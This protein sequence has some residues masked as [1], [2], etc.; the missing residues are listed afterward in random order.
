MSVARSYAQAVF[1]LICEKA[2]G[3]PDALQAEKEL[4]ALAASVSASPE[5][6]RLLSGTVIS[7]EQR[8]A[9]VAAIA[10]KMNLSP[11][12]L[13][14]AKI[15]AEKGR[16]SLFTQ[17]H[18]EYVKIRV[19]HDGGVLGELVSAEPIEPKDQ[20]ELSQ[21]FAKKL[22]KKIV[23]RTKVDP[24]LIAGLKVVVDGVTYDGS[25]KA[26]LQRAKA[27]LHSITA[28]A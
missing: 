2:P 1:E 10:Q 12:V 11:I 20:E 13:R 25:V 19:G 28:H 18:D 3:A 14:A 16:V 21:A 22:G 6:T 7:S 15:A 24:S 23:F 26:Q 27:S 8:G 5:L 4:G 9:L 17:I